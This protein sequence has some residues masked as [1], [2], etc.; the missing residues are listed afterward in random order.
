MNHLD[1]EFWNQRYLDNQ[2]GWDIGYASTPL[3]RYID[4]LTNKNISVLIPGCG[5]AY[6]AAY[7]FDNGFHNICLLDLA[8]AALAAARKRIPALPAKHFIN[9]DFFNHDGQYDLILEQTFFCA[10][11]P[12]LRMAYANQ[13]HKLLKPGGKLVGLL[14][15]IPLNSDKPPF[16]GTIESYK[17][18][19]Q[20]QFEIK[21]FEKCHNSIA[22]RAG[23]ELFINLMRI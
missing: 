22:P 16:G 11:D 21:S 14:F 12:A 19:F 18:V 9:Q 6:E 5:N 7:L 17:A 13:A 4:Q 23:N 1:K 8:P 2:T 15:D 3:C 10:I 20:T